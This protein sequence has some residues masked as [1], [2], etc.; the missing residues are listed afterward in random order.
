MVFVY[1]G[2]RRPKPWASLP[3]SFARPRFQICA[4]GPCWRWQYSYT[5]PVIGS[6]TE[7]A[8]CGDVLEEI[9]LATNSQWRRFATPCATMCFICWLFLAG[10]L[11]LDSFT[12]TLPL[13]HL[14]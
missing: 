9:G 12:H 6:M 1:L 2:V 4:S 11:S 8:S 3:R 14:F 5:T 7:F 13:F 10:S